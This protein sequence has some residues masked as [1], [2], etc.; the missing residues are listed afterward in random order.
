MRVKILA[1]GI[2]KEIFGERQIVLE[3]ANGTTI[4]DLNQILINQ[5]PALSKLNSLM[6][7]VNDEYAEDVVVINP[8]DE[9]ALI[10]PVSGG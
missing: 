7:A 1:F 9:I 2:I 6:V 8:G 4:N 10:P 3:L 5:F